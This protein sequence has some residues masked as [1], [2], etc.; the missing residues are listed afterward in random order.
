MHSL[1]ESGVFMAAYDK[2]VN[3]LSKNLWKMAR[4]GSVQRNFDP[5]KILSELGQAGQ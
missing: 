4:E 1:R 5:Q 3:H 2:Q